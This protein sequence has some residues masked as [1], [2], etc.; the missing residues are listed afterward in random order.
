[1]FALMLVEL[2][3]IG[4][5]KKHLG[6]KGVSRMY[7]TNITK[8]FKSKGFYDPQTQKF[9]SSGKQD[10]GTAYDISEVFETIS[11][12]G[13]EIEFSVKQKEQFDSVEEE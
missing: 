6:I 1:M 9:I 11:R 13:N 5:F 4:I 8:E 7:K 3:P 2:L 12:G 10:S